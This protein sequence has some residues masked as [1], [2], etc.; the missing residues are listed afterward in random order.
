LGCQ[1]DLGAIVKSS[2]K[3][4]FLFQA[5]HFGQDRTVAAM[6]LDERAEPHELGEAMNPVSA[7]GCLNHLANGFSHRNSVLKPVNAGSKG[8]QSARRGS[9]DVHWNVV[10]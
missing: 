6:E 8:C 4:S 7:C 5:N 10:T 1:A 2:D 9:I 3:D